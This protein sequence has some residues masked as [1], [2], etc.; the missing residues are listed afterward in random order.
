M[1]DTPEF[2]DSYL[3]ETGTPT[4]T[5][6]LEKEERMI[7]WASFLHGSYFSDPER[8]QLQFQDNLVFLQGKD[9]SPLWKACQMQDLRWVRKIEAKIADQWA[10]DCVVTN[11]QMKDNES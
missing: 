1:K 11:L 3:T 8:I 4:L 9:L 6:K 2:E 7:P 5:L 10:G